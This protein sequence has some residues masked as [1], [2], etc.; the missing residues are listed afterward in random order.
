[1]NRNFGNLVGQLNLKAA[2]SAVETAVQ[3]LSAM[4]TQTQTAR[5][6]VLDA[7]YATEALTLAKKQVL[8]GAATQMIT[9]ATEQKNRLIET[10]F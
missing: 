8:A 5:G 2:N 6:H 9:L 3:R 4:L 1:M 7:D 10:L